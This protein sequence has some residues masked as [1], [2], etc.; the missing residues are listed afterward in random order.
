MP[1]TDIYL[2][3][4]DCEQRYPILNYL[5]DFD[6]RIDERTGIPVG[7]PFLTQLS[8]RIRR[9]SEPAEPFYIDWQLEPTK[10]VNLTIAFYD[11]NQLVR[12]I[13]IDDA[14]LVSYNQECTTPGTIEEAMI[15]SPEELSIDGVL[16]RRSDAA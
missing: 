7:R 10:K 2:E 6:Q 14:Y 11:T 1:I 9:N 8:V 4:D 13:K 12:T 15:I 3:T 5:I 16:F